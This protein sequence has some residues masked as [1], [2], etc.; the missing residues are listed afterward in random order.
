MAD[1]VPAFTATP[2]IGLPSIALTVSPRYDKS[3][4]GSVVV[5]ALGEP[6]AHADARIDARM[7]RGV[8]ARKG[9]PPVLQAVCCHFC[10]ETHAFTAV[11]RAGITSSTLAIT[12]V[13]SL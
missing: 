6:A 9:M 11:Q 4:L 8:P 7:M 5:G 13:K 10:T 2:E 12:N 1:R 3:E